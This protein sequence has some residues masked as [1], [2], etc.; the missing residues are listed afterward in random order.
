MSGHG[1]RGDNVPLNAR[2]V[3][4]RNYGGTF[5]T[6]RVSTENLASGSDSRTADA[7][8]LGIGGRDDGGPINPPE[9]V[10]RLQRQDSSRTVR[11]NAVEDGAG[12]VRRGIKLFTFSLV[13]MFLIVIGTVVL[14]LH[15][16]DTQRVEC[17]SSP[18]SNENSSFNDRWRNW[19]LLA[20]MLKIAITSVCM[21]S[22]VCPPVCSC[23]CVFAF[24][25]FSDIRTK[26]NRLHDRLVLDRFG[27]VSFP[28]RL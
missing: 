18:S 6:G 23:L 20:V 9:M 16:D 17:H 1:G 2:A 8:H 19:A 14:G 15:W 27:G 25:L 4:E 7:H 21:V 11:M 28:H 26:T 12:A 10:P 3:A 5:M 13:D 22:F 24:P